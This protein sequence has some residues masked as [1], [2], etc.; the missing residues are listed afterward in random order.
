VRVLQTGLPVELVLAGIRR[1][2]ELVS[3]QTSAATTLELLLN[4]T[5]SVIRQSLLR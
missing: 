5:G 3:L 1:P 4:G 2:I